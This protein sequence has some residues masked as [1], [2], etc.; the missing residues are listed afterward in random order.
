MH[1]FRKLIF[2]RP[3]WNLQEYSTKLNL[4]GRSFAPLLYDQAFQTPSFV[5][6]EMLTW[7]MIREGDLKLIMRG[8]W[9]TPSEMYNLAKNP[10]ELKNVIK[11]PN[12]RQRKTELKGKFHA[13]IKAFP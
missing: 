9:N 3:S 6:S 12:Y 5:I 2:F 4:P 1:W 11:D 8:L 7:K 10:Y 13:Q